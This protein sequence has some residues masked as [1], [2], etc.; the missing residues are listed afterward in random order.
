MAKPGEIVR[1]VLTYE[2]Y[3]RLPND[4]RRY[5]ILEGELAVT[6]APTPRHQEVLVNLL[7]L[8]DEH[9]RARGLGKVYV[10]P[11]DVILSRTSVVQPDLVFVS[12]ARLSLVSTRG[13]E[14]PPDLVVEVLSP[15]T[16]AQDRGPKLQLYA[17]YGVAHYWLVDAEAHRLE[18]HE[19]AG[20]AY[21]LTAK[22][23]GAADFTPT[24]FPDHAF[25]LGSL[26]PR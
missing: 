16:E 19:L 24:L 23:A 20:A 5:E 11:I 4:G 14:G 25:P 1:V 10:A 13:I 3:C 15:T 17:G 6:P 7:R 26:W 18:A 8:L 2:D 12:T 22:L 9:V 21:R